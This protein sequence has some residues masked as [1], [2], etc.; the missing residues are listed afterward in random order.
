MIKGL[1]HL[2]LK[3]KDIEASAEFYRKVVGLKEAFRMDFPNG[4][5]IVY[6]YIAPGQFI[7]IFPDG[8]GTQPEDGGI[9]IKHICIEVDDAAA[10]LEEFRA[11]GGVIDTPLTIGYAKCVQFWT[12]DPDGNKIEFMELPPESLQYQA[13]MR[14]QARGI[15]EINACFSSGGK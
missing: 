7:E 14:F 15:R 13:N 3:A 2:A 6:F 11:R 10:F 1:G 8:T 4:L 5:K 12:H 9:G